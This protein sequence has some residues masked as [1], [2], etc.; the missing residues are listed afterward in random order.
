MATYK[1]IFGKKIQVLSSDPP[2]AQGEGQIWY[3]STSDTFKTAIPSAAWSS[4]GALPVA[5]RQVGGFGT[6]T[7]A[8]C[9]CGQNPPVLAT[10][11]EYNG[12]SWTAIT[13]NPQGRIKPFATGIETAGLVGGGESGPSSGTNAGEW[14]GSAWGTPTTIPMTMY[15]STAF[16]PEGAA[17]VIHSNSPTTGVLLYNGATWTT[18]TST[19]AAMSMAS[20]S[21]VPTAGLVFGEAP[22]GTTTLEY[23]SGTWSAGGN[24]GTGRYRG[25]ASLNGT[26]SSTIYFGGNQPSTTEL[27]ATES[28]DGTSWT[29]SPSSLATARRGLGGAGTAGAALAFAGYTGSDTTATEEYTSVAGVKTITTS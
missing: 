17:V 13:A 28:Y 20:A 14:N 21:G 25:A 11:E 23:A 18:G 29:A 9:V 1:E 2:A 19:P 22:A 10:A 16:G 12:A 5:K 24:L 3:N 26:Q 27:T 6:Q 4:G 7:A 15:D 8:I